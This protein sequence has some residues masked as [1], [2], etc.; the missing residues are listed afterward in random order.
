MKRLYDDNLYRFDTAQASYWEATAGD[1]APRA[2]VLSSSESCDVAVIGGGYTGLATA[3]HLARDY[4]VDVRVLEAGHVGWGASG[5]NG[6]FCGV[7]GTGVHGKDLIRRCGVQ[8]ARD[9]YRSQC[10]A[11]ELVRQ[12]A[13]DENID[14]Q[15]TGDAEVQVAHTP[16]AFAALEDD[17]GLHSGV[18][19]MDSTLVSADEFRERYYDSA[20]QHGPGRTSACIQ[21]ATAGASHARRRGTGRSC[22]I[23][24]R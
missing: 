7:G 5:R 23:I 13:A 18:L 10:E 11:V 16:A 22:T 14:I 1:V 6:G 15:E 9:W 12:L 4:H 19:G 3:L 21:C 17:H 8:N 2:T 24:P 20:E